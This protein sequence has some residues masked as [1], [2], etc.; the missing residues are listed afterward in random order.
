MLEAFDA[1]LDALTAEVAENPRAVLYYANG[2]TSGDNTLAGQILLAAGFANAATD[3]GYTAGIR[4]PLEL[5]AMTDPDIVITALP[6]PR[7]VAV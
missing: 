5:L 7:G 6:Y 4:L 2:Y 3:A 1:R